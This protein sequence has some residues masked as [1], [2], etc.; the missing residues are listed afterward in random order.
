MLEVLAS[1]SPHTI[2]LTHGTTAKFSIH[3]SI[4]FYKALFQSKCKMC[5]PTVKSFALKYQ[6]YLEQNFPQ[7]IEEMS[8]VAEGAGV[9]YEDILALN[10]R[11][12]IAFGAFNDGCTA[13]SWK[14][15]GKS[16]LGQNWDWNTEFVPT[17]SHLLGSHFGLSLI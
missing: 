8:G 13:I 14:S 10:V 16:V 17:F 3:G 9:S 1:G 15:W 11:T 5:W 6:S 4:T 12:E 7:Y 2:G